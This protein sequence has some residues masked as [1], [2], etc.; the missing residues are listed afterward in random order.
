[1]AFHVITLNP[2]LV[3]CKMCLQKQEVCDICGSWPL[4]KYA[5]VQKCMQLSVY[6]LYLFVWYS[7]VWSVFQSCSCALRAF[8]LNALNILNAEQ[9]LLSWSV[10]NW[11]ELKWLCS[12]G[13][14]SQNAWGYIQK[15]K[16]CWKSVAFLLLM[17]SGFFY[18]FI[19]LYTANRSS[20]RFLVV[21]DWGGLPNAP[22]ITPVEWATA[23]EMGRTAEQLGA[24]FVLALGDNFY[25]RG[26]T[27]VDDPRFQVCVHAVSSNWATDYVFKE[28]LKLIEDTTPG[29]TD[30]L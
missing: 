16:I 14:V 6:F 19:F 29:K 12:I 25:Y 24:D 26:V 13:H 2:V 28:L 9:F 7:A 20:I 23:Q 30:D 15:I 17:W 3:L 18:L 8:Y 11:M 21:G 10:W 27:S 22:F 1:M 4:G 5:C